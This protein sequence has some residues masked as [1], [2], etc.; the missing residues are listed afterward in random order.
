MVFCWI[1]L[2]ILQ[3]KTDNFSK[4]DMAEPTLQNENR[5]DT[6]ILQM[7]TPISKT[8]QKINEII[9]RNMTD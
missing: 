9:Q 1:L 3:K 7:A 6:P 5:A 4:L 2:E 8:K